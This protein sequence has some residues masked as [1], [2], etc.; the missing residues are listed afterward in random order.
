M[1][2]G[3]EYG[4]ISRKKSASPCVSISSM[5]S[6]DARQWHPLALIKTPLWPSSFLTKPFSFS[7]PFLRPPANGAKRRRTDRRSLL[8]PRLSSHTSS[9]RVF[10]R[11]IDAVVPLRVHRPR[12]QDRPSAVPYAG[13]GRYKH[14]LLRGKRVLQRTLFWPVKVSSGDD[15]VNFVAL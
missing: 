14:D 13:L 7:V 8:E 12:V 4:R 11:E 9:G 10:L 5:P 15:K 1:G 2:R 3:S 6:A